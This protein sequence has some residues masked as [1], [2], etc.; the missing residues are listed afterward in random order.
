MNTQKQLYLHLKIKRFQN[1]EKCAAKFQTKNAK[2]IIHFLALHPTGVHNM[3]QLSRVGNSLQMRNLNVGI[4]VI[5]G[6][7]VP[8]TSPPSSVPL[9]S[10][11]PALGGL[12]IQKS[13]GANDSHLGSPLAHKE[14]A[15][16]K[17]Y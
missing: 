5:V 17:T 14:T 15:G 2:I 10:P 4:V 9:T 7:W 3:E 6:V 16:I 11:L 13:G 12:A 1:N 8:T